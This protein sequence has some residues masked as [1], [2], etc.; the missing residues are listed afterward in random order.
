MSDIYGIT[1]VGLIEG[2][3]R[4]ETISGNAAHATTPGF[5]RQVAANQGTARLFEAALADSGGASAGRAAQGVDL[6]EGQLVATGRPLDV[7]IDGQDGFFGL[8]DGRRIWLTRA[9][10]FR[11]AANGALVGEGGLRVQG[12]HGDISLD[13]A[14]VEVRANGQIVRDGVVLA[15]LRL[16]KPGPNSALA[17]G[18]GSLLMSNGGTEQVDGPVRVR[19][20]H[21]E[22][23]NAT[24][25]TEILGLVALTRQYESLVRVTQ[26]YDDVLGRAIQ[27]LGEI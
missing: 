11:L 22:S 7:A 20:G 5:R 25:N 4:L 9:G 3:R 8:S 1:G 24:A 18:P 19:S 12:I 6:R 23:S 16:F 2:Q 14:D 10:S 15:T 27:R 13:S 21:V 26:G 17:A